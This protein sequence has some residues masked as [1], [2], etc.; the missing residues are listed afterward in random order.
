MCSMKTRE[1]ILSIK[2]NFCENGKKNLALL[3]TGT[4]APILEGSKQFQMK[5]LSLESDSF[6]F[7]IY[8]KRAKRP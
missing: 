5:L 3:D 1:N 2:I 4:V 7:T 6:N 8:N